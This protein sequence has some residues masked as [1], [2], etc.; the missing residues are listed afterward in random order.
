MSMTFAVS[1]DSDD[2]IGF[3]YNEHSLQFD[4]EGEVKFVLTL[5][6]GQKIP[7]KVEYTTAGWEFSLELPNSTAV[8]IIEP[9]EESE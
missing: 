1:G 2:R 4:G 3:S 8:G 5:P 7:G 6:G 9:N